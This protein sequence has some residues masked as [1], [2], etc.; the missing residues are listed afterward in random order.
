MAIATNYIDLMQVEHEELMTRLRAL[1]AVIYGGKLFK[2]LKPSDQARMIQQ[3][4][5]MKA[6]AD[7][8]ETRI[9]LHL[10]N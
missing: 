3:A 9:W 4:V 5:F 1:D 2:E 10:G 7:V 6:Y 8:L